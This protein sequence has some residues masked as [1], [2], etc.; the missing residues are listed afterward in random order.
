[1]KK[2]E[3]LWL[4]PLAVWIFTACSPGAP[5]PIASVPARENATVQIE[6]VVAAT[7]APPTPS[8]PRPSAASDAFVPA[9]GPDIPALV[10]KIDFGLPGGN[11]FYPYHLAVDEHQRR[12]YVFN[13]GLTP[14]EGNT[15]SVFDQA[16]GQFTRLIPLDNASSSNEFPAN[17]PIALRVDPYRPHLYA[18]W[19]DPYGEADQSNL[20][21]I[22][23]ETLTVTRTIT[24]VDMV[25][26]GPDRLYLVSDARLWAVDP[27]SL[28]ELAT[29]PLDAVTYNDWLAF[30][31][32]ANR[33]YVGR[34]R[35]WRIEVF[36]ADTLLPVDTYVPGDE[37]KQL[38]FDEGSGRLLVVSVTDQAVTLQPLSVTGPLQPDRAPIA[39]ALDSYGDLPLVATPDFIYLGESFEDKYHLYAFDRADYRLK[40]T[41]TL[42]CYVYDLAAD[43]LSGLIYG[44]CSQP[45]GTLLAINP[46]TGQVDRFPTAEVVVSALADSDA[47][48]LYALTNQGVLKV[49]SL[50]DQSVLAQIQTDYNALRGWVTGAGELALDPGK[51]R[52]YIGGEPAL[53]INTETLT[54]AARLDTPGQLTPDPTG[55]RLYLT[56]PCQCRVTQCNTL[57]LNAKALTGTQTLFPPQDPFTAPCVTET[58]LDAENHM[59]YAHISNG[60]PGSNAGY[61]YTVFDVAAAPTEVGSLA[62]ISYSRAAFDP[63]NR[64]VFAP[65]YRIDQGFLE[66]FS[67]TPQ[68]VTQTMALK[69][70]YGQAAYDSTAERLYVVDENNGLLQVFDGDLALMAHAGLPQGTSLLTIDPPRGKIYLRDQTGALLVAATRGGHLPLPDFT[71]DPN[72]LPGYSFQSFT[73]PDGTQFKLEQGKLYQSTN[74][75]NWTQLGRGLFNRP[76]TALAIS[77]D[78]AADH[79]LLAAQGWY[80]WGG[81]GLF[82]STD[83]G[84]TWLPATRGLT[85]LYVDRMAFSPT[86]R[87]DKTVFVS[88][89]TS[90]LFRS[91]DGGNTWTSLARTYA[92]SPGDAAIKSVGLS[93]NFAAD[94]LILIAHN[95]LKRSTDS[96]DTWTDSGL[97]GGTIAFSPNF[98]ADSLILN[99]GRWRSTDG[100]LTWRP[101]AA[102]RLTFD[103]EAVR[104]IFSP[105]FAADQTVYLH[106]SRYAGESILQ[107]STDGGQSWQTL[108]G[109]EKIAGTDFTA[110][111]VLPDGSLAFT[112]ADDPTPVIT[113]PKEATWAVK[114]AEVGAFDPEAFILTP[115]GSMLVGN[116]QAGVF[117][118]VDQGRTWVETG[119]PVRAGLFEPLRLAPAGGETIFASAGNAL[120]QSDDDGASWRDLASLPTGYKI[121]ALAVSPTFSAEKLILVGGNYNNN[122]ILRSVD[123]GQTWKRVFDG[124]SVPAGAEITVIRFSPEFTADQTVYAWMQS[125]GLLQSTNAGL[126]WQLVYSSLSGG[127][128]VQSMA[129]SAD[130]K[131]V[132]MGSLDGYVPMWQA[133][134]K[135]MV[136][137]GASITEPRL[138]GSALAFA[139]DGSLLLGTDQAVYRSADEGQTWVKAGAGLPFPTGAETSQQG[140]RAF[141]NAGGLVYTAMITGGI[142]VSADNGQTWQAAATAAT[143][144]PATATPAATA[145]AQP[146]TG[147]GDVSSVQDSPPQAMVWQGFE[148]G[149][150]VWFSRPPL[151][152]VLLADGRYAVFADTWTEALNSYSCPNISPERT[153]P[154]P[155]RGF[156]K[157]WCE[158]TAVREALGKATTLEQP[159]ESAV[160]KT[161][162]GFTFTNLEGVEY[163]IDAANKTWARAN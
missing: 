136:D 142:F 103:S 163:R 116:A 64:R 6:A 161:A 26:A 133:G 159:F 105:D 72:A 107:R 143:T 95:T 138:W 31:A 11:G 42:P 80:G 157:V 145:T 128:Y 41:L 117:K 37:L 123:G 84:Q 36:A 25:A 43:P 140:V 83:G 74:G 119:F 22:N 69:G 59:L 114:T 75:R 85:E 132:M 68:G 58:Q 156:G 19:G 54:Q 87:R 50:A 81:G 160:K 18:L 146:V 48:R 40:T 89:A 109:N 71:P 34:G 66:R 5:A 73:A 148:S 155:E 113:K 149:Y 127:Y 147:T 121:T 134:A 47:G 104:L 111:S 86:Y 13:E 77:P 46:L 70:A 15:I 7:P 162:S 65:R 135:T 118:S 32:Q 98:A 93:P 124:A 8:A 51:K 125:G 12:I 29:M 55:E 99:D 2:F 56:L 150:M 61:Y 3:T 21:I 17:S 101:A 110:V 24:G 39:L 9:A 92:D 16:A 153:P 10:G 152:H 151:I 94:G 139:P 23:T 129:V 53:V 60:T 4:L 30:N 126:T 141:Q 144:I 62:D 33:L 14:Q 115:D 91:T 90:G 88:A 28:A 102:G 45:D 1:M 97:P 108:T 112:P 130:G 82:R 120:E 100:G 79:T 52:L 137:L 49:L 96:G 57:I 154:T 122:D 78:F 158:N 131:R 106:L 20:S 35:P 38:A 63:A 67:V 27:D 76:V 44:V